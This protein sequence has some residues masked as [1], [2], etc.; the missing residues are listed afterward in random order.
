MKPIIMSVD[1]WRDI[2]M[3]FLMDLLMAEG[4][5]ILLVVVDHFSRMMHIVLRKEE[6][7]G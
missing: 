3:G 1:P 5:M 2:L 4:L 6:T 7:S